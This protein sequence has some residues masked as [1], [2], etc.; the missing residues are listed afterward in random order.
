[1]SEHKVH[2]SSQ[3]E[4]N[5]RAGL[6]ELWS[7]GL[8]DT[9]RS[10]GFQLNAMAFWWIRLVCFSVA[11]FANQSAVFTQKCVRLETVASHFP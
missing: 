7:A 5:L 6:S 11:H 10:N 9:L 4:H 1:M 2:K 3:C 8:E